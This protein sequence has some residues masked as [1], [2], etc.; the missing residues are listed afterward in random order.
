M[1]VLEASINRFDYVSKFQ[2]DKLPFRKASLP[3]NVKSR[4]NYWSVLI[5]TTHA[6]LITCLWDHQSGT[7]ELTLSDLNRY[8]DNRWYGKTR[9]LRISKRFS[10]TP[11][12]RGCS[13]DEPGATLSIVFR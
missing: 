11:A 3:C 1:F 6:S 2:R 5:E 4:F 10:N 8:L 7:K 9:V 13:D 12:S